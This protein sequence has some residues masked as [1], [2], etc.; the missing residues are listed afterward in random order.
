MGVSCAGGLGHPFTSLVGCSAPIQQAPMGS[1]STPELAVAVAN[2]GGV[3]SI[4]ALGMPAEFL[5]KMLADMAAR[6]P[7][8]LA[9][10]F[11]TEQVDREA[12][13]AAAGRVRI[14]DFFWADPDSSLIEIAHRGGA[15]ACWQV[16][17]LD[18]ALAAVDAG[19]DI[20]AAQRTEAGGH[21]RGRTRL[22]SLLESV[23]ARIDVPSWLPAGSEMPKASTR[24]WKPGPQRQGSGRALLP[25]LSQA[26]IP[27]ISRRS[28]MQGQA[29]LRSPTP[30]RSAR[31]VRRCL[32][33]ECCNPAS[34]N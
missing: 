6:T 5:D 17:S 19:C 20:V 23:L 14:I 28:S 13:A 25:R 33:L 3:G 2:A 30:S 7:G 27:S 16:G 15:L 1:V 21:V 22:R 31:F 24:L 32:G 26:L 10:N 4:T 11:L 12:V 18:E 29:R 9:V 8:S 34:T